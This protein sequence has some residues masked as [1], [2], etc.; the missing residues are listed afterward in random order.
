MVKPSESK[1]DDDVDM[2]LNPCL[3][4]KVADL[5]S[6]EK[7]CCL[8]FKLNQPKTAPTIDQSQYSKKLIMDIMYSLNELPELIE[9]SCYST[10]LS[11]GMGLAAINR[12]EAPSKES[13]LFVLYAAQDCAI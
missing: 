10:L 3:V 2:Y 13:S 5:S 7:P 1:E 9:V 11:F 4:Y 12:T 6:K 8:Y